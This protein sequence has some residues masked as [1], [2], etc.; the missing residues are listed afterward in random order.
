MYWWTL[1]QLANNTTVGSSIDLIDATVGERS[2]MTGV[3]CVHRRCQSD[4][5]ERQCACVHLLPL[6]GVWVEGESSQI[7]IWP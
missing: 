6:S 3:R 5:E 4:M 7:I 2:R 1:G